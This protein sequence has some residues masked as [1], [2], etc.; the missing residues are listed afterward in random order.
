MAA[1]RKLRRCQHE[2]PHAGRASYRD[3]VARLDSQRG[4][5]PRQLL[6]RLTTGPPA[7][8]ACQ[9]PAPPWRFSHTPRSAAAQAGCARPGGAAWARGARTR[10]SIALWRNS[11]PRPA[12]PNRRFVH[13]RRAADHP[14]P[15]QG[16]AR[17]SFPPVTVRSARCARSHG[18]SG[19]PASGSWSRSACDAAYPPSPAVRRARLEIAGQ[20]LLALQGH[21]P[22]PLPSPSLP[23]RSWPGRS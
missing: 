20:Q 13:P 10:S 7:I 17:A 22:R 4:K 3:H 19:T 6:H 9:I 16:P 11:A 21:Q 14:Q 12:R 1:R 15:S 2:P 23:A 8:P 18:R 5:R